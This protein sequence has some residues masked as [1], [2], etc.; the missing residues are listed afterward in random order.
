VEI[1]GKSLGN[2]RHTAA[3]FNKYKIAQN[4][5]YKSTCRG[6]VL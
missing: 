3:F 6:R 1:A 5:S 2:A 4:T